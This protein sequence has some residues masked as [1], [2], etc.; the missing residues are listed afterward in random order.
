MLMFL[1]YSFA[2]RFADIEQGIVER[3]GKRMRLAD[4]RSV[5]T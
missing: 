2:G 5:V 3:T 4:T 1:T